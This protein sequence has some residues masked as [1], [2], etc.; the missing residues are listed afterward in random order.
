MRGCNMAEFHSAPTVARQRLG[1]RAP[2]AKPRQGEAGG[3]NNQ[4]SLATPQLTPLRTPLLAVLAATEHVVD[5]TCAP[6]LTPLR[7]GRAAPGCVVLGYGL[8]GTTWGVG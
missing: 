7:A 5:A 4:F 1:R 3:L 6:L 2:K 8:S